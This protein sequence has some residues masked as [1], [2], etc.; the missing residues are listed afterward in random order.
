MESFKYISTVFINNVIQ[1]CQRGIQ[2][3]IVYK[4]QL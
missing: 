1:L 4:A 3:N 2:H